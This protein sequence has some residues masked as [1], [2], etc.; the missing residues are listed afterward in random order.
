[1]E[2]EFKL[3]EKEIAIDDDLEDGKMKK[4]FTKEE[5]KNPA[6]Y[7]SNYV[8]RMT[9]PRIRIDIIRKQERRKFD[10]WKKELIKRIEKDI[11]EARLTLKEAYIKL[12]E[13]IGDLG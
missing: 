6:N 3:S 7:I 4:E 1:M 10:K 11:F 5:K 8:T 9:S 12:H 2:K 13:L